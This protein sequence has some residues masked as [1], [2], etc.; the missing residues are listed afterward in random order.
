M[1]CSHGECT[2]RR[3]TAID[4]IQPL[5]MSMG[6]VVGCWVMRMVSHRVMRPGMVSRMVVRMMWV[7][8]A[9]HR[10][11]RAGQHRTKIT[12]VDHLRIEY[13]RVSTGIAVNIT[14]SSGHDNK[15]T[16]S[17]SN[18][19]ISVDQVGFVWVKLRVKG[20][21]EGISRC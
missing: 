12:S 10:W 21:E 20:Q 3:H 16:F 14:R 5:V 18:D 7:M 4:A 8:V 6:R 15:S 19:E 17:T 13:D 11:V 1:R 2:G 9:G